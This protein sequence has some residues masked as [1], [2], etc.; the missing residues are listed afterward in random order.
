MCVQ[1]YGS[2]GVLLFGQGTLDSNVH[3]MLRLT[4]CVWSSIVVW[5]AVGCDR[6][7]PRC[8]YDAPYCSIICRE[9]C[10]SYVVGCGVYVM[11]CVECVVHRL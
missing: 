4:M 9:C 6:S 11:C 2:M 5:K 7:D 10:K 1:C 3:V 8:A